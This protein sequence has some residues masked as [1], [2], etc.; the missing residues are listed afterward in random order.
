MQAAVM[1]TYVVVD[2]SMN[3]IIIFE[4]TH[5]TESDILS[6]NDSKEDVKKISLALW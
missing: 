1:L 4:T 2:S 6:T 3:Q 5:Y